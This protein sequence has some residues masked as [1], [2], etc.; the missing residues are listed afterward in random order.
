MSKFLRLTACI[1]VLLAFQECKK[2]STPPEETTPEVKTP[3]T[4]ADTEIY[5]SLDVTFA[6]NVVSDFLMMVGFAGEGRLTNTFYSEIPGSVS[7]NSGT[8]TMVN[9]S[10]GKNLAISFNK[11]F[12]RD[13]KHREGTVFFNYQFDPLALPSQWPTARYFRD[14]G[15]AGKLSLTSFKVNEWTVDV[16]PGYTAI[17]YNSLFSQNYD[18]AK[19]NIT[20]VIKGKFNFVNTLDPSRN[21][22]WSGQM[23]Q[24]LMNTINSSVFAYSK[25]SAIN[26]RYAK[27]SYQGVI[28]GLVTNTL[29]YTYTM[30]TINPLVRNFSCALPISY[31]PALDTTGFHPF[32]DGIV[33]FN[34]SSSAQVRSIYYGNLNGG[35]G[36]CNNEGIIFV[37]GNP[38]PVS[39]R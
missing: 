38:M 13:G 20:W 37:Q 34:V 36:P 35:E 31:T 5:S 33:S 6:N 24:T 7:A 27:V 21:M 4:K 19:T 2:K 23:K 18:P 29:T 12:G 30:D 9:D 8:C 16:A 32:T 28:T 39:F 1:M 11:T 25:Q 10:V 14:F 15:Y 3:L 26:W 22:T 17:I